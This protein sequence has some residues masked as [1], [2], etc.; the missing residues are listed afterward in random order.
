MNNTIKK[1]GITIG[2]FLGVIS[3]ILSS[4]IYFANPKL[5]VNT[6]LGFLTIFIFIFFGILSILLAKNKLGGLINFKDTFSTYFTTVLVA[7]TISA[8]FIFFITN[9]ILPQEIR[10]NI[11]NILSDFNIQN[12]KQNHV[13]A[14]DIINAI[15]LSKNYNPFAYTEIISGT[16][17]YLLRDSAIGLIIAAFLR[18]TK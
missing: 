17:K 11:K 2:S 4:Y 15:E 16:F 10:D 9:F 5:L 1:T 3:V 13:S 12:M 8:I 6:W 14:K 18:N 7:H